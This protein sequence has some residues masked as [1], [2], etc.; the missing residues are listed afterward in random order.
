MCNGRKIK[1]ILLHVLAYGKRGR[2]H[3]KREQVE[4]SPGAGGG[5]EKDVGTKCHSRL[6]DLGAT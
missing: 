3:T 4:T 2:V 6:I 1:G 5:A